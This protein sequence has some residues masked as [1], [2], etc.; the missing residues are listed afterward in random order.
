[1][2]LPIADNRLLKEE[3]FVKTV[4]LIAR[5]LLGAIFLVFGLNGFFQF[6][7]APPMAGL[8]GEFTHAL[9][10]SGYVY[11]VAGVQTIAGFL[12]LTNQF[13][14]LA[15]VLLGPEIVNILV[16]HLSMQPAGIAPG[17]VVTILWLILAY[18]CRTLFLPFLRNIQV[19]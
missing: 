3:G 6:I 19:V 16:F 5:I 11:L 1:L 15:L 4:V 8:A 7:P 10:A 14:P 12:L 17:I 2:L 18:R 13:A 9:I